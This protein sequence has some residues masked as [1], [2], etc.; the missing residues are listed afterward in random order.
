MS[1]YHDI[2]A[3][4]ESYLGPEG[5]HFVS[6][7]CAVYLNIQPHGL[8]RRHLPELARWMELGGMRLLD[9]VKA[10]EMAAKIARL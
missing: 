2:T 3:V 1:L 7:Q 9:T 4:S 6:R 8:T 5:E 10:K